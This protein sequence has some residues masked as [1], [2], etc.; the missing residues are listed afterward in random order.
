MRCPG[1]G[2]DPAGE[3]EG[4]PG[5]G[6]VVAAALDIIGPLEVSGQ[7]MEELVTM[8]DQGGSLDWGTDEKSA[9]S[10]QRVADMLAL[11]AASREYQFE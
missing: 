7:T 9:Q 8:A 11:I 2:D 5:A 6:G 3:G 10:E 4:E 1:A